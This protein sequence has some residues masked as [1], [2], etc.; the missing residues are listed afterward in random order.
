MAEN[1]YLG[2]EPLAPWGMIDSRQM[3]R[4]AWALL[5]KLEMPVDPRTAVS[6]LRVGQQQVVEIAKALSSDISSFQ[7]QPTASLPLS[8]FFILLLI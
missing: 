5:E 6:G 3:N 8:R 7:P 1:I 2:R 4:R